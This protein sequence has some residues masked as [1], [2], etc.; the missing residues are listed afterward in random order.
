MSFD[1]ERLRKRMWAL[2]EAWPC[3]RQGQAYFQAALEMYPAETESLRATSADPFDD[4]T[5]IDPFLMVLELRV[6]G[7]IRL[8]TE[9]FLTDGVDTWCRFCGCLAE[10][11]HDPSC[12]HFTESTRFRP[13]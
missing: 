6:E 7:T 8:V 3:L 10:E 9:P 12:R 11:V 2:L 5:L 4:D 1:G 13:D